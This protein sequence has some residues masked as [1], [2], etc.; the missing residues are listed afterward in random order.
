MLLGLTNLF[1]KL[2][3]KQVHSCF[4]DELEVNVEVIY[5]SLVLL[6]VL[7]VALVHVHL[8]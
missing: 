6:V 1:I 4:Q 5:L 8:A 7:I 2:L 3:T